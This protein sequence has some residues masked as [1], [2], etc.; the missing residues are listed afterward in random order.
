MS[1]LFHLCKLFLVMKAHLAPQSLLN[2][3]LMLRSQTSTDAAGFVPVNEAALQQAGLR[4]RMLPRR[5]Y[6]LVKLTVLAGTEHACPSLPHFPACS[7]FAFCSFL[8][9][10]SRQDAHPGVEILIALSAPSRLIFSIPIH[11]NSLLDSVEAYMTAKVFVSARFCCLEANQ[12]EY[13]FALKPFLTRSL[14]G[15]APL[16][17]QGSRRSMKEHCSREHYLDT[18]LG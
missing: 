6:L 10:V 16:S 9:N 13:S 17:Q 3:S 2:H 5:N 15:K 4:Q 12:P 7:S 14:T 1:C 18:N 8:S 11:S